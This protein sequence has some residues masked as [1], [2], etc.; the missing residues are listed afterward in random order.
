MNQLDESFAKALDEVSKQED[1]HF[2]HDHQYVVPLAN[3]VLL[4]WHSGS[5]SSTAP[6][7]AGGEGEEIRH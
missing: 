6:G 3:K 2:D 7:E 4:V 5:G 1:Q